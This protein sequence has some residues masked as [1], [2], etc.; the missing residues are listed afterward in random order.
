M[1]DNS[2]LSLHP[3]YLADLRKSGLSDETIRRVGIYSVVPRD[4]NGK[5]GFND[6]KIESVMAFPYPGCDGFEVLKIFPPR[7]GFKYIQPKGSPNRLYIPCQVREILSNPSILIHLTEGIKKAL[8]ACQEGLP[9]IAMSGLWNWSDGSVGKKLIS[10]FNLV[11]WRDRKV[12][13]CPDNDWEQPDRHGEPKN[14]RQAVYEL[15][16]RLIHRGAKV[17]VNE[18]PEGPEK[19]GLDDYL[20]SHSVEEF[21]ALLKREIRRLSIEEMIEGATVDTLP[22]IYRELSTLL[23]SQREIYIVRIKEKLGIPKTQQRN[24]ILRFEWETREQETCAKE[25]FDLDRL[26][27]SGA[28][29]ESKFSA[30]N[31]IDGVLS[32]GAILGTKRVLVRSDGEVKLADRSKENSFRFK[33][34]TLTAEAIKRFRAGEDVD[35]KNLLNRIGRLFVDHVVFRDKRI[36]LLL[37][38]WVVGSYLYKV[39]R[40]F[41][42]VWLNSP[43]KRCGKTLLLE[44]LSLV[45]FNS[46][47]PLINPS[48]AS[49]FREVDSNDATLII[50]EVESLSGND[51]DQKSELISLINSGFQKGSQASRVETRNKEF[52]VTYY[53]S[54]SPKVLAGIK[55]IVD[56][57]ED[58]AFKIPMAR[59][60]KFEVIKRFNLRALDS[61]IKKI[62]EDCFI[63]ALRYASDVSEFYD[64]MPEFPGTQSLDDRLKDIA[65][66]LLSIASVIGAQGEE[67]EIVKVLVE[68]A[69]DLGRGRENQESLNG[70]IP[71]VVN[72]MKQ[73]MD[74]VEERFISV[75]EMFSKFQ[76]DDDLGFIQS[77]KGLSSF[78][79][80][81]DLYRISPRWVE[82]KTVRGYLVRQKWVQDLEGRYA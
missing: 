47:S 24:D 26:L 55:G 77:K 21:H 82:G 19:V 50:D 40:Y 34:S 8:K 5:I 36:S 12:C 71:A 28:N 48:E 54:Y 42:Y 60:K 80:K 59:K 11:Q 32:Y 43:V 58:R 41:G 57:I 52:I 73:M 6:P 51:K 1:S 53:N 29:P 31:F 17:W 61:H 62:R 16:Y 46:T 56:T 10:D 69:R 65:E 27:E 68:L 14:L 45:C 76:G 75:D 15:A 37:A 30:Q 2:D 25:D 35:G 20:Y 64:S 44:I 79:S 70:S 81:L 74:G 3:D 63:W 49:V 72:L 33:R 18:L 78:L 22:E 7:D 13:I 39:F 4:I 38:V 67:T 23:E 66:P 9:C